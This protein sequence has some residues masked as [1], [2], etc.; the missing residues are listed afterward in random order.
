MTPAGATATKV[1]RTGYALGV[2]D[3]DILE[4]RIKRLERAK[5]ITGY[6]VRVAETVA[7]RKVVRQGIGRH[8]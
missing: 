3:A 8:V 7:R 2:F 4:E 6:S 1:P 5:V